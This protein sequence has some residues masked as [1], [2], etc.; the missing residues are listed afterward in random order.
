[1]A[2]N[3]SELWFTE[4]GTVIYS[5]PKGV[6]E[7]PG[8]RFFKEL[9]R[10]Y[11]KDSHNV[12]FDEENNKFTITID[13]IDYD[14]V[15]P[16]ESQRSLIPSN[17]GPTYSPLVLKLL[18]LSMIEE[19][20]NDYTRAIEVRNAKIKEMDDSFYEN[21]QTLEDHEIYAEYL[22]AK[23]KKAKTKEE[24]DLINTK[25]ANLYEYIKELRRKEKQ[26]TENPLNLKLHINRFIINLLEKAKQLDDAR[27]LKIANLLKKIVSEYQ[28][29]VNE[30]NQSGNSLK[31]G[32][33][34]VSLEILGKIVDVEFLLA[35]Y[36]KEKQASDYVESR[37]GNIVEQLDQ[38]ITPK[39]KG[40]V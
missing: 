35:S 22:E 37:M 36:L 14:V 1:M 12:I 34:L 26:E 16:E 11:K 21:M 4:K 6:V 23:Y 19:Q 25:L 28:R 31:L 33:P 18:Y 5:T 32:N 3:N 10:K 17:S 30:Y 13:G 38:E 2:K 39:G 40:G 20:Y 29:I 24:R 15:L 27:R 9:E 7:K 8:S